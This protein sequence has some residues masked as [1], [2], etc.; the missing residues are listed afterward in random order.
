MEVARARTGKNNPSWKGGVTPENH[1]IRS[2]ADYKN[3][4]TKVFEKDNWTCQMCGKRGGRLEAHHKFPFS[5][6][7][8]LRFKGAN[9]ITLC[10]RCHNEIKWEEIFVHKK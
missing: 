8:R 6:F 4:R 5:K 10:E 9:G 7:P 3:W 1:L 2:S